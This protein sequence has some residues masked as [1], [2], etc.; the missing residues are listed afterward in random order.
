MRPL[1]DEGEKEQSFS[2]FLYGG[3]NMRKRLRHSRRQAMKLL[4]VLTLGGFAGL[5]TATAAKAMDSDRR[6]PSNENCI[7]ATIHWNDTTGI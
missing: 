3:S 2:P 5:R 4:G 7:H 6:E 1:D